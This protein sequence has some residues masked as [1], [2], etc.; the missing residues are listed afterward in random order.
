MKQDNIDISQ[1][2]SG[3]SCFS[4]LG[5]SLI[6]AP[7]SSV[8]QLDKSFV[9]LRVAQPLSLLVL[10]FEEQLEVLRDGV[11]RGGQRGLDRHCGWI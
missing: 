7:V 11:I 8:V 6:F 9:G 5:F 4:A 10:H 1:F 3:R 2:V